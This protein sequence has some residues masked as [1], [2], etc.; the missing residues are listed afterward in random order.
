VRAAVAGTLFEFIGA[1]GAVQKRAEDD[2]GLMRDGLEPETLTVDADRDG[3]EARNAPWGEGPFAPIARANPAQKNFALR[4]NW[5]LST[6]RS[7]EETV[8]SSV[9]I[10]IRDEERWRAQGSLE[11][12]A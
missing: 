7:T 8:V 3:R 12:S 9:P 11:S 4:Q 5:V 10:A 6:R 2:E 1:I